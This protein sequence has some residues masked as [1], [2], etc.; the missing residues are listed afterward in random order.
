MSSFKEVFRYLDKFI[1]QK[2]ES[3]NIPG[4]ALALTNGEKL[5]RVSTYGFSDI[6]A[7][8]PVTPN[9]LFEI[10]SI[11][12]SFTCIA[13]LQLYERGQ[14]DPDKPVTA[15]LPWFKVQSTYEPITLH[16]LMSHTAGIINGTDFTPEARYQLWALRETE[17][18]FPPGTFFHYSNTGYKALG[19]I[20]ENL[21]N[22]SY[23]EIIQ[24]RILD[25]LEMESTDSTI[26]HRTRNRLA[27][28]YAPFYDDRPIHSS[29]QLV[30]ATWLETDT[31]DGCIASTAED[32]ATYLRMLINRGK[33]AK[34]R[35]LS[36]ES[37]NLML[38]RVIEPSDELHGKFYGYGLNID[39][40]KGHTYI[41]HGGGMVGYRSWILADINDGLGVVVLTNG[42]QDPYNIAQFTLQ[43]LRC[44]FHG[45]QMPPLPQ[46]DDPSQI[47]NPTDYTGIYQADDKSFVLRA[48][49]K[50]L[51]MEY[52][53]DNI[54]LEKRGPDCFYVNH[55]HFALF[56]L[57]F[58]R[59]GNQVVEAFHG[60][61]WYIN[62]R[63]SGPTCFD[64]PREWR[65]YTGHYRSYNPWFTNFRV[66][67]RKG[68]L[69]LIEPRGEEK[70]LVPLKEDTFRIGE[71]DRLPERIRFDTVIGNQAIRA[72]V[73]GAYYYRTFTP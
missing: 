9:T 37:F 11:G 20:L 44:A 71:D 68:E 13:L 5:L 14:L 21:L 62:D 19:L 58:G 24:S 36:E 57:R 69:V 15:Y 43:L 46:K 54:A 23:G 48:E 50:Q 47:T 4:I 29:H 64:Y 35:I 6:A 31:A 7:Q 61:D 72:K 65:T 8:T 38:Q 60:P 22:Q 3:L 1:D 73:G 26:T 66:V 32:M 56:L 55:P 27:V 39:E 17:T 42:C 49:G 51:I 12:K 10:G 2:M 28:G 59:E 33:G 18:A 41:G 45:Q 63:Y 70:K 16:H 40:S 67:L 30:P 34:G 53:G 52:E 25:P